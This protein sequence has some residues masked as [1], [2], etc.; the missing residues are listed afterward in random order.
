MSQ[1]DTAEFDGAFEIP[2][3]GREDWPIAMSRKEAVRDY[4]KHELLEFLFLLFFF[5]LES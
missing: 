4:L 3:R 1:V 5:L 2:A